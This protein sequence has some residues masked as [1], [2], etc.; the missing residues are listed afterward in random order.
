MADDWKALCAELVDD[1]P[2][3]WSTE[4]LD[5]CCFFCGEWRYEN[6]IQLHTEDCPWV[7]A[8]KALDLPTELP[9]YG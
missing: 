7:R 1:N 9:P 4:G 2:R 3:T 5:D 6:N 8:R